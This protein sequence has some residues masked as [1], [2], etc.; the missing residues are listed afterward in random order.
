MMRGVIRPEAS[1]IK[2]RGVALTGG[3]R[4]AEEG[5]PREHPK[6]R[7]QCTAIA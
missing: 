2:I 5:I 6:R 3:V 7:G 1:S 4:Q